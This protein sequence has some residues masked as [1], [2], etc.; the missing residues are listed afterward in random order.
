[1]LDIHS[2]IHKIAIVWVI[3][4][5]SKTPNNIN[6]VLLNVKTCHKIQNTHEIVNVSPNA[7]KGQ[8][9]GWWSCFQSKKLLKSVTDVFLGHPVWKF[10]QNQWIWATM[11]FKIRKICVNMPAEFKCYYPPSRMLWPLSTYQQHDLDYF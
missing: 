6:E 9:V 5:F 3:C 4:S 2:L 8:I 7:M 10:L 1:M 11:A